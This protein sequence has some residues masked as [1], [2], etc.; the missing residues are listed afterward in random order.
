MNNFIVKDQCWRR[1]VVEMHPC[2]LQVNRN[3]TRSRTEEPKEGTEEQKEGTE[4]QEEGTEEQE[5]E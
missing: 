3:L 4:E 1:K 2:I 5:E